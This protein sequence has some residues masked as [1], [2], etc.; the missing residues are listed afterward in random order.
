MDKKNSKKPPLPKLT[1]QEKECILRGTD[2]RGS[3]NSYFF[4]SPKEPSNDSGAYPQVQL[5][6][7]AQFQPQSQDLREEIQ[8]DEVVAST[9]VSESI[10]EVAP[11]EGPAPA[12]APEPTKI[13]PKR[14]RKKRKRN[15]LQAL[16]SFFLKTGFKSVESTY[17]PFYGRR[18][19]GLLETLKDSQGLELS[20]D[21]KKLGHFF[22]PKEKIPNAS[23]GAF[24]LKQRVPSFYQN[25]ISHFAFRGKRVWTCS[26]ALSLH[27]QHPES[28]DDGVVAQVKRFYR[29]FYD[30][31]VTFGQERKIPSLFV[32]LSHRES[33]CVEEFGDFP[34]VLKIQPRDTI[35]GLFRGVLALREDLVKRCLKERCL[36]SHPGYPVEEEG[37]A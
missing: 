6:S 37:C 33:L 28:M 1:L 16:R 25:S 36:G 17:H 27:N 34:F 31:L 18:V 23:S 32:T 14:K 15:V 3:P 22:F 26:F 11:K 20:R 24:L 29:E 4:G 5:A 19:E 30:T 12:A 8:R 9:S 7:Q 13:K 35:D 21:A 10:H 2:D